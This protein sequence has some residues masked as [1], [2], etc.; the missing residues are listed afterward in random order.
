[1]TEE[2]LEGAAPSTEEREGLVFVGQ[3]LGPLFLHDPALEQE[4]VGPLYD[5]L[6]QADP[7]QLAAEWPFAEADAIEPALTQMIVG[8]KAGEA[9]G[10]DV[11]EALQDGAVH[12]DLVWEY[13]RL[14][15]GP[16]KKAAPPWGSVYTDKDQVVFGESTLDLREWLRDNAVSVTSGE[17]DEP[18][19]HIGIMLELMAWLA[20]NRPE[21]VRPYLAQHLLTWAPHFLELMEVASDRAFF[22]G[23][24]R[25]TAL[26][27]AAIQDALALT[28]E[29][30]RFYR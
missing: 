29:T 22:Q 30:P 1:M 24:A 21:L 6:A 3:T 23:L 16:A 28:V 8:L 15:V 20:E 10:A 5:A 4:A 13:R 19:D 14:F 27:F 18:E 17:S 12:D 7:H 25:T 26:T 2:K 11:A 9:A